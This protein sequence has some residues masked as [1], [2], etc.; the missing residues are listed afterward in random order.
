MKGNRAHSSW[1]PHRRT[2]PHGD[3]QKATIDLVSGGRG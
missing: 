3:I 1:L 2:I